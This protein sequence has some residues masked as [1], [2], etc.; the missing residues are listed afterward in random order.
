M[1]CEDCPPGIRVFY[2]EVPE[3]MEQTDIKTDGYGNIKEIIRLWPCN[4]SVGEIYKNQNGERWN[5]LDEAGKQFAF[6]NHFAM[7]ELDKE[8]MWYATMKLLKTSKT[9]RKNKILM[10][11]DNVSIGIKHWNHVTAGLKKE[12]G[13]EEYQLNPNQNNSNSSSTNSNCF[14]H[15]DYDLEFNGTGKDENGKPIKPGEKNE[16]IANHNI[17]LQLFYQNV[18]LWKWMKKNV[19]FSR[20]SICVRL[21]FGN[22][23]F[24]CCVPRVQFKEKNVE[25]FACDHKKWRRKNNE[26]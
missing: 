7:D 14:T 17:K 4:K 24:H 3:K 19:L 26:R 6:A 2:N 8:K 12:S 16:V 10:D 15:G 9:V 21:L 20:F 25:K 11:S 13:T 1:S 18:R 5:K 22:G 23:L